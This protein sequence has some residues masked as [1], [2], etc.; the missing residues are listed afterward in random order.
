MFTSSLL[1]FLVLVVRSAQVW[2]EAAQKFWVLQRSDTSV[3]EYLSNIKIECSV[4]HT[5]Y[6]VLVIQL[7]T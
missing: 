6:F 1:P 5:N 3:V 4:D 7:N 2:Q